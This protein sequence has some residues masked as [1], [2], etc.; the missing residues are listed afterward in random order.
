MKLI[1]IVQARSSSTR[2]SKK[3]LLPVAG[4]PATILAA[5]RA[6]NCGHET[7]VATSDDTS[8]DTLAALLGDHGIRVFRGPLQ[9]VLAR[10][11][12][13]ARDFPEDHILARLTAD[14]VLPDGR[15]VQELAQSLIESGGEYLA[16]SSPQSRLPY[17]LGAE[18]F[19]VAALRKA[20]LAASD[21]HDREHVGPWMQR[22]CLSETYIPR[23]LGPA[24]YSHLR[25]TID[26]EEDYQRVLR[27]FDGVEHPVHIG[28]HELMQKLA[29]LPGEASFRI[30]YRMQAESICSELTLGTAQLGSAYGIVNR[31][32]KP[33]RLESIAMIRR[34]IAYGV[35]SIDTA[36]SYGDAESVLG[37]ALS[38]AWRSRVT[39]STKL[40][41]LN[42]LPLGAS[43][44][45]VR[46]AV[47]ESVRHSCEALGTK[48]LSPFLLHRWSHH[49]LW[50]GAAWQQLLEMRQNGTIETLGVSVYG[51]DEALDALR[52]PH[53][54]HLQLPFNVLDRR[55]K[56]S[57][58]TDALAD[59]PDVVVHA[60]SAFLQGLLLNSAEYW[61]AFGDYDAGLCVRRLRQMA[62]RFDRENVA[63]LCLAYVRSQQWITS[64]VVGCETLLQLGEILNFFRFP[65]LTSLQSEELEDALPEA[66]DRL[67]NPL[68]WN[69]SHEP[70]ALRR[71]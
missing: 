54:Q 8:D 55:W 47:N 66:P 32:G 68:M 48:K 25:C 39:V 51:P 23:S 67:L 59:R 61:P 49:D 3:A 26:D 7:I 40:D 71:N 24:D 5:L 13:A 43:L 57:G 29:A 41:P 2:L 27:L 12:M 52:D 63:D 56:E 70:F 35:T 69:L 36:R 1:V 62:Q 46:A 22:H 10:Y 64:V 42:S 50:Q 4:Y 14:N 9:D 58:L 16:A 31:T 34:A 37:N 44:L 53:I 45:S 33:S 6:A 21:P 65:K 20:H 17:G 19:S 11:Y 15:F 30:P 18:V 38:G 60:R 28:W